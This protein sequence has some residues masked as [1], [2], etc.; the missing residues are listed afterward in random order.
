MYQIQQLNNGWS[1][2]ETEL[3]LDPLWMWGFDACRWPRCPS[4]AFQSIDDDDDD[5]GDDS[6]SYNPYWSD[7]EDNTKL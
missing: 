7:G 2:V 3:Q 6:S 5:D 4:I 1:R